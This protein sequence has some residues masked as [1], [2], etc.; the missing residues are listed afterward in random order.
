[1]RWYLYRVR[2]MDL[3]SIIFMQ[4]PSFPNSICWRGCL[5]SIVC[6]GCLYQKSDGRSCMDSYCRV[7][8]PKIDEWVSLPPLESNSIP[9][10]WGDGGLHSYILKKEIQSLIALPQGW[11]AKCSQDCSLLPIKVLTIPVYLYEI[12]GQ[13]E[14]PQP[15]VKTP[16]FTWAG[17]YWFLGSAALLSL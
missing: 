3:I 2:D 4:I 15:R 7:W 14:P 8:R 12:H 17:S 9:A 1:L 11:R 10:S 16:A 5:F 13:W 6:F